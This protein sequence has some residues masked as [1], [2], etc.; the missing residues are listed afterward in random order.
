M[1]ST[2]KICTKRGD[3]AY[4]HELGLSADALEARYRNQEVGAARAAG[5]AGREHAISARLRWRL[6][7]SAGCNSHCSR[8]RSRTLLEI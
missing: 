6:Q 2:I 7:V 1:G 5:Q 4:V 8:C 3:E